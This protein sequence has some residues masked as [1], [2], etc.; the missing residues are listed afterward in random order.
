MSRL[1]S[2]WSNLDRKAGAIAEFTIRQYKTRISTWVVLGTGILAIVLVGLFHL[3]AM[4]REV[5][6]IDQDGDSFDSDGDG[7]VD[8]H[9]R[10]MGTDPFS[11]MDRPEGEPMPASAFI[12]EDDID[13]T[14]AG[15]NSGS[16]GY[17]DDGDCRLT[18]L[19]HV[20]DSWRD[21]NGNLI[22]CD[23]EIV[24]WEGHGEWFI[25]SD[26][27]VDEDPDDEK[28][29]REA[30]HRAFVLG[31]GKMGIVYLLGIFIPLFLATGLVRDE[32]NSGTMHFMISKPIARG[33]ILLYRLFGY[34]AIVVPYLLGLVLLTGMVTTAVAP[35]SF[36][37]RLPELGIWLAIA[38]AA[39][40]MALVYG[41]IF[42]TLGIMWKHGMIL[43]MIYAAWEL[44]MA[45][46]SLTGTESPILRISVIGWGVVLVDAAAQWTW[47]DMSIMIESGRWAELEAAE[48]LNVFYNANSF[49]LSP[50]ATMGLATTTLLVIAAMAWF[51]GQSIFKAKEVE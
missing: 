2:T 46:L 48:P 8:G 39:C 25:R 24:Q 16:V 10:L 20:P 22:I 36:A 7:Y 32:M 37:D 35:G 45:F 26:F 11:N 28:Y 19:E 14:I 44:G 33:E 21:T 29:F 27:N 1:G 42:S 12:D 51:V 31:I 43:A 13:W 49:D 23:V 34:S 4:T 15:V 18:N 40:L 50:L 17:D 3:D 38:F 41:V 5:E 47:G 9:E 30:S 6:S